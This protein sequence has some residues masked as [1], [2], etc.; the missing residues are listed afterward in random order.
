MRV[1]LCQHPV[2]HMCRQMKP[3]LLSCLPVCLTLP[4]TLPA[5]LP[6]T[7]NTFFPLCLHTTLNHQAT[8]LKQIG[9]LP[10]D[11]PCVPDGAEQAA[12]AADHD[13]V[14]SNKLIPANGESA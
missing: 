12:K 9:L 2:Q 3:P 1:C 14:P 13:A 10:P 11:L 7:T 5:C 4:F 6:A 8:V